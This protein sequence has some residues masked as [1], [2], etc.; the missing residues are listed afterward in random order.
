MRRRSAIEARRRLGAA[1]RV[2]SS[3]AEAI[4]ALHTA[5]GERPFDVVLIDFQMPQRN[6]L[7]VLARCARRGWMLPPAVLAVT[8]SELATVAA[9]PHAALRAGARAQAGAPPGPRAGDSSART[10]AP[11]P[12]RRCAGAAAAGDS[13]PQAAASASCSSRTTR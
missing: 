11:C 6:G 4:Q 1:C 5:R 10:P 3:G 13:A 7:D 8:S 2:A 9:H 12:C